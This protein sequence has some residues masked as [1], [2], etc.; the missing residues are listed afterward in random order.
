MLQVIKGRLLP[1]TMACD[2]S[3]QP[4]T[5]LSTLYSMLAMTVAGG[6]AGS[7]MW[8]IVLPIDTAKTRIQTAVPGSPQDLGLTGHLKSIVNES[9]VRALWRGVV[10]AMLRAFPANAAQWL[11]W[12]MAIWTLQTPKTQ[13]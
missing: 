7:V 12:E 11:A 5:V 13:P 3:T 10:P 9:G 2:T 1:A 4:R 8:G 6:M